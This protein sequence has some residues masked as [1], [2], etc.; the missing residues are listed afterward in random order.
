MTTERPTI[1]HRAIEGVLW[2]AVILVGGYL[3]L[4]AAVDLVQTTQQE[5]QEAAEAAKLEEELDRQQDR[6][7]AFSKDPE[8]AQ[9]IAEQRDL[10]GRRK[11]NDQ[12]SE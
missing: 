8:A 11:Q 3:L 5:E 4:P 6:I 10:E 1:K 2:G 9:K 12:R 7:D